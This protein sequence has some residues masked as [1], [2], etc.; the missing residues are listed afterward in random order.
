MLL[1]LT[2]NTTDIIN[3]IA[4]LKLD[5]T[6]AKTLSVDSS[7]ID[8]ALAQLAKL[9]LGLNKNSKKTRKEQNLIKKI[10]EIRD[11][12]QDAVLYAKLKKSI[13]T[14]SEE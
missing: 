9:I 7:T 11:T 4:G 1:G 3:D 12:I 5:K 14:K 2:V 10:E 6:L 13:R 8:L